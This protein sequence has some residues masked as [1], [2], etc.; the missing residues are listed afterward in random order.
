MIYLVDTYM[1]RVFH[2]GFANFSDLWIYRALTA[3][4]KASVEIAS[5]RSD[6]AGAS[7]QAL[8]T[9]KPKSLFINELCSSMNTDKDEATGANRDSSTY[10]NTCTVVH[11]VVPVFL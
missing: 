6:T 2:R 9:S 8:I 10:L 11:W 5:I 4:T 7:R 1:S 3:A